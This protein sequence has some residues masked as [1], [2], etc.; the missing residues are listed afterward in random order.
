MTI[1]QIIKPNFLRLLGLVALLICATILA[2]AWPYYLNQQLDHATAEW[3]KKFP[4]LPATA[5]APTH[6][7]GTLPSMKLM[8]AEIQAPETVPAPA[9]LPPTSLRLKLVGAFTSSQTS[10]SSALIAEGDAPPK[11]YQQG[12][13]IIGNVILVRVYPRSIILSESG[14]LRTLAYAQEGAQANTSPM[15]Q[16][17]NTPPITPHVTPQAPAAP[18]ERP[19]ETKRFDSNN[20]NLQLYQEWQERRKQS[21]MN[22]KA[23][24]PAR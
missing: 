13:T 11:R 5:P 12:D 6:D 3:Q 9:T 8:G 18:Q 22:R 19:T 14:K 24:E 23:E 1:A 7:L 21:L 2:Y 10:R 16:A 20:R 4:T 17:H 15:G